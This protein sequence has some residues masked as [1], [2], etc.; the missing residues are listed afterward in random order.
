MGRPVGTGAAPATGT[1]SHTHASRRPP[2]RNAEV[3]TKASW[4]AAETHGSC[5]S[6]GLVTRRPRTDPRLKGRFSVRL[7]YGA[8]PPEGSDGASKRLKHRGQTGTR[9]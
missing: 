9:G 7:S 6:G 2:A 5:Q 3:A 4:H 8:A 1:G